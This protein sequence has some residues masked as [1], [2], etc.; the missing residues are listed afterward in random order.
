[1]QSSAERTV[2]TEVVVILNRRKAPFDRGLVTHIELYEP[3][4]KRS[5]AVNCLIMLDFQ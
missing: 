3:V 1:M 4:V 5:S 2:I